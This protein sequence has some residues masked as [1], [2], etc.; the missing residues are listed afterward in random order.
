M[1]NPYPFSIISKKMSDIRHKSLK[2][3]LKNVF[4]GIS[5]HKKR[6]QEAVW[7]TLYGLLSYE[8]YR[9]F[10]G[11]YITVGITDTDYVTINAHALGLAFIIAVPTLFRI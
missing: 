8:G 7:E 4:N 10:I 3:K 9:A 6:P 2:M 11:V 5:E 1:E